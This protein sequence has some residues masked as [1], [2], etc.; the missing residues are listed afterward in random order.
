MEKSK[1]FLQDRFA[2][3]EKIARKQFSFLEKDYGFKLLPIERSSDSYIGLR[4][5]SDRVFVNLYYGLP[6]YELDFYFG[7]LGIEDQPDTHSFTS[8]DLLYLGGCEKWSGYSIYSAHSYDNLRKCLPKLASLLCECG[9]ACLQGE[10][11]AYEQM[12]FERKKDYNQWI[13]NQELMQARQAAADAWEKRDYAKMVKLFEPIANELTPS[14]C[15]K[16]EY[17]RKHL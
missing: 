17:S 16:L 10:N 6:S 3:F 4:Y 15:K 7:R 14:E 8:G 12:T 11:A 1:D 9:K 2:V 13:K 5:V